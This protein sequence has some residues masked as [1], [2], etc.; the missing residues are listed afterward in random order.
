MLET[1][2]SEFGMVTPGNAMKWDTIEPTQNVFSYTHGDYI[3]DW[4]HNHT[5]TVR[6]HVFVWHSQRESLVDPVSE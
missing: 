6:G 4:A 2:F 5:Q 3:V 1:S